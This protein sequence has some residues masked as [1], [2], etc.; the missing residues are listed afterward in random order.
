MAFLLA[1]SVNR[2]LLLRGAGAYHA[3]AVVELPAVEVS[4]PPVKF[5]LA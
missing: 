3:V 4:R 5:Y 1:S 2:Q